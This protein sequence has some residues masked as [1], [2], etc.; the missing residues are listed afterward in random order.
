MLLTERHHTIIMQFH[1]W[2]AEKTFLNT[3][4]STK[5]E[6]MYIVL[7][8]NTPHLGYQEDSHCFALGSI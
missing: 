4:Q 3:K 6:I 7:K 8:T 1:Y 2:T 5:K